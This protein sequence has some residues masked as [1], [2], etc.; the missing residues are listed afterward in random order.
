MIIGLIHACKFNISS[1]LAH[2]GLL[3]PALKGCTA[4]VFA[5]GV[6]VGGWALGNVC[7]DII[8]ETIRCRILLL[9]R[10]IGQ[11]VQMCNVLV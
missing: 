11:G 10:D 5:H 7:P 9:G 2:T 6:W 8:S 3:S 4:I 1:D